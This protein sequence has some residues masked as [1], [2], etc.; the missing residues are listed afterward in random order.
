MKINMKGFNKTLALIFLVSVSQ[1]CFGQLILTPASQQTLPKAKKTKSSEKIMLPF[2][3][4]F[5]NYSGNPSSNLWEQNGGVFINFDYGVFP[6]SVGVATFDAID[7]Q[8]R[9]YENANTTSFNADTLTSLSIRLDSVFLPTAKRLTV[10]DSLYLSFYVQPGGGYGNMW[11]R[12]GAAPSQKD[13]IILEFYNSTNALWDCVWSMRGMPLDTLYANES[14][15]FRFVLIPIV[16]DK[17]FN[18]DF[19]FRFR[20]LASLDENTVAAFVGNCDQWNI[21][22]VYLNQKRSFDDSTMRDLAF[23]SKAQ[24]LIKGYQAMPSRQFRSSNM[25]DSL[26]VKIINLDSAALP[27]I[28]QYTIFDKDLSIVHQYY[29]G[30]ENLNPFIQTK[31]YQTSPFHATP[32]VD[33]T[34][35]VDTNQWTYF[36][37]VHTVK[38]GVGQ[39]S[40]EQ[41]DTI[42]FRQV[43]ENYYAY[44]DGTAEQGIGV[45]G[46]VGSQIA[47]EFDLNTSDTLTAV[48]I[49]FNSTYNDANQKPF[50]LCVW[51]AENNMPKDSL[52]RSE[53]LTPTIDGLNKFYR[54]K[55]DKALVVNGKIF[56]SLQSK[57]GTYLN[58][59]FDNNTNSRTK[60][61]Y[62]LST[63]WETYILQGSP[64]IRPY[65]GQ[66]AVVGFDNVAA[67]EEESYK[68]YPNPAKTYINIETSNSDFRGIVEIYNMIGQ[69]MYC[70]AFKPTIDVS[71]LEAGVYIIK[72]GKDNKIY[73]QKIII[74]K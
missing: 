5:S 46:N 31:E 68:I 61:F 19:R 8:G 14:S 52:Y 9:L 60:T 30:Y 57:N 20:N 39:D 71:A 43:F 56:I 50:Y 15:Y 48:D 42:V 26:N 73:Q 53:L 23:V 58:I 17:Y 12:I 54:Y 18:D 11:E 74:R 40:R 22:Y 38:A 2:V 36:D 72:I 66:A 45:Q 63:Q 69:R 37:I 67:Q 59:G 3:E 28:Y 35:S 49:Y 34:Y 51:N 25:I 16:D 47:L 70:G 65:F 29:G 62:N 21:D 10:S 24:S 55:L 7:N 64:M 41:N 13:S 44:D 33:F 1:L 32:P 6:P 27:T 4:D